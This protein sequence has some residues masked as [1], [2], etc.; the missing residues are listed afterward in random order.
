M[1][2]SEVLGIACPRKNPYLYTQMPF[3]LGSHYAGIGTHCRMLA[4]V[5]EIHQ[6][7]TKAPTI[8]SVHFRGLVIA[9]ILR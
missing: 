7:S 1:K 4:M 3:V 2:S 8:Q 9:K 5:K 6:A